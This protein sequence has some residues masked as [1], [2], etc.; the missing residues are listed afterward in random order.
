MVTLLRLG[1]ERRGGTLPGTGLMSLEGLSEE[2]GPG[3]RA[4]AQQALPVC[5]VKSEE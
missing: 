2:A 1:A 5:H 4:L 3:G